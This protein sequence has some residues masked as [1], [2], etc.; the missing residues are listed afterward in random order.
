MEER[1]GGEGRREKEERFSKKRRIELPDRSMYCTIQTE[2]EV[3]SEINS[4]GDRVFF[5]SKEK[6]KNK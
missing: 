5:V 1:G 2:Q 6:E 4:I 3:D